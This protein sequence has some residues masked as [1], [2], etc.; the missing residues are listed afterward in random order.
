MFES[1]PPN[2]RFNYRYL[3]FNTARGKGYATVAMF[4]QKTQTSKDRSLDCYIGVSFCSPRDRFMKK[5]GRILSTER[6]AETP[7]VITAKPCS[8]NHYIT[9]NDF[10]SMLEP[11]L[12]NAPR[13]A[14]NSYLK[15]DYRLGLRTSRNRK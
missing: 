3:V 14:K 1:V 12:V 13:W 5:T 10:N 8:D 2:M 4:W 11:I 6:I 7:I 9:N 15:M